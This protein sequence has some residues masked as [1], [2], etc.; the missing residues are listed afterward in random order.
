MEGKTKKRDNTVD[1]RERFTRMA[2]IRVNNVLK[3]LRLVSNLLNKNNYSYEPGEF[4]K[5]LNDISEEFRL[6]KNKFEA[7]EKKRDKWKL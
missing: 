7:Q 1:K 2:P 4:K 3:Q 6:V 5:I